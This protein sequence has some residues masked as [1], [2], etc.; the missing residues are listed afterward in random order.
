M[1]FLSSP[2]RT[3]GHPLQPPHPEVSSQPPAPVPR[4]Y[5][6]PRLILSGCP[7]AGRA[8]GRPGVSP[9][10]TAASAWS[11]PGRAR[12]V[13]VRPLS[14][15]IRSGGTPSEGR[16]SRCPGPG[17]AAAPYWPLRSSLGRGDLD[18][19]A[20]ILRGRPPSGNWC[21][22]SRL[23]LKRSS[24]SSA[25]TSSPSPS[26]PPLTVSGGTACPAGS[27]C[28]CTLSPPGDHSDGPRG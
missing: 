25:V 16:I 12:V 19:A 20:A 21:P 10:R 6:V 14:R 24:R 17:C 1:S 27:S 26:A 9:A 15:W 2:S 8:W 18:E 7:R 13:P 5:Q 3:R 28:S 22:D 23:P 11:G 4:P